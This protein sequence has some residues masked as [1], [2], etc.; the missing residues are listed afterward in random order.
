MLVKSIHDFLSWPVGSC[1]EAVFDTLLDVL[2]AVALAH[3]ILG[4]PVERTLCE[5]DLLVAHLFLAL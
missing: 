1:P 3:K 5:L 2:L 4:R